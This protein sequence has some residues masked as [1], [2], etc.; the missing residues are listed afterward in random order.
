[1]K[2]G[3]VDPENVDLR[4]LIALLRD[5]SRQFTLLPGSVGE[6]DVY[7]LFSALADSRSQGSLSVYSGM[8]GA[9]ELPAAIDDQISWFFLH[10]LGRIFVASGDLSVGFFLDDPNEI[11]CVFGTPEYLQSAVPYPKWLAQSR[12]VNCADDPEESGWPGTLWSDL[13]GG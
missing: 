4:G 6:V 7:F 12:F 5:K 9:E 3:E 2:N 1:M 8:T 11:L 10:S 13:L